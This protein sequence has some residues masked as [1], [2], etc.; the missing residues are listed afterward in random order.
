LTTT[1]A[2]IFQYF[3]ILLLIKS[4]LPLFLK[5]IWQ[6]IIFFHIFKVGSM[7]NKVVKGMSYCLAKGWRSMQ[8]QFD[9]QI[10]HDHIQDKAAIN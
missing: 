10:L 4:F 3:T 1:L 9:C 6:I 2:I 7:A 8:V 5:S